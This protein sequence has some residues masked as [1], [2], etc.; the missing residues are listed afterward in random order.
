M[1]ITFAVVVFVLTLMTL[2]RPLQVPATF[3]IN[4]KMKLEGSTTAKVA[5]FVVCGLTAWLYYYF[6]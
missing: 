4:E 1:S 3:P 5:A 6:W 2:I